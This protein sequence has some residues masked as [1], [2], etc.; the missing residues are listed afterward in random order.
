MADAQVT[1]I[2][3]VQLTQFDLLLLVINESVYDNLAS[4]A[5]ANSKSRNL[6]HVKPFEMFSVKMLIVFLKC[7]RAIKSLWPFIRCA[8]LMRIASVNTGLKYD[9]N[10]FIS[11]W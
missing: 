1:T 10:I 11:T 4:K 6:C 5:H 7:V 8:Q 2:A 9:G 3:R